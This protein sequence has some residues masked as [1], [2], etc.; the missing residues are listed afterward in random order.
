MSKALEEQ[1]DFLLDAL[2]QLDVDHDAGLVD[3]EDYANLR[4]DYT[5]RAA[6]VLRALDAEAERGPRGTSSGR[7]GMLV[8]ALVGMSM[9]VVLLIIVARS[10]T[11]R[12]GDAPLTGGDD[13]AARTSTVDPQ[14]ADLLA[15]AQ[16]QFSQQS[17]ADAIKTYDEI[18]QIDPDNVEA[19]T[20]RG[21][22]LRLVSLQAAEPEDKVLLQ[23]RAREALDRAV[24]VEPT[25]VDARVFRAILLRDLGE[26]DAALA[27][28]DAVPPDGVPAFMQQMVDGVRADLEAMDQT[29]STLGAP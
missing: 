25:F 12:V 28:L 1:R 27:D 29:G 7:T 6:N 14:V 2:R 10:A 13:L 24:E 22:L 23:E 18:L 19:L 9:V 11:E 21:W 17:Y 3:D 16:Q 4:D 8:A 15:T 20:Y 5:V 26:V